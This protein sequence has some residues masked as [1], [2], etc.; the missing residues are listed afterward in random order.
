MYDVIDPNTDNHHGN[1]SEDTYSELSIDATLS[2]PSYTEAV[3][4]LKKD[5]Y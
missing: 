5:K 2:P 3:K 1:E 4:V